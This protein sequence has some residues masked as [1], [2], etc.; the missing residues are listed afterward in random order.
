MQV[1][2]LLGVY[3]YEGFSLLGVFDS[4]QSL[5]K[6]VKSKTWNYDSMGFVVSEIGEPCDDDSLVEIKFPN[7]RNERPGNQKV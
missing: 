3:D 1:F 5:R 6:Y 4:E 7:R 2:T